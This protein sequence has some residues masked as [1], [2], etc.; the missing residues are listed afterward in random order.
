MGDKYENPI[1]EFRISITNTKSIALFFT[2][3]TVKGHVTIEIEEEM[4]AFGKLSHV[5]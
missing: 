3:E 1:K 4:P 2:G 5:L